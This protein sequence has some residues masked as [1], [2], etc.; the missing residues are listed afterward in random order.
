MT[1]GVPERLRWAVEELDIA[2]DDRILEVGCGPGVAVSLVAQRL[3][4]GSVTGVDRSAHAIDRATQRNAAHVAAGR[5]ELR[6][7]EL[8]ALAGE[9][10]DKVFAVN[11]NAFW[12]RPAGVEW[13]VVMGLLRRPGGVLHLVYETPG[14]AQVERVAETLT[15][16]MARHSLAPH[17]G[18]GPA[19][20]LFRVSGRC[21]ASA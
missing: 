19:P 17:L 4:G 6:H 1:A 8:A 5:V 3:G 9:P 18:Y 10:F 15:T 2:P 11:V 14:A 20:T 13:A 16:A 12:L 21:Y 7:A